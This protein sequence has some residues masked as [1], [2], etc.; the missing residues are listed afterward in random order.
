MNKNRG[1]ENPIKRAGTSIQGIMKS[2]MK[3]V[4]AENNLPCDQH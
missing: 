2:Q 3:V 4:E 1:R